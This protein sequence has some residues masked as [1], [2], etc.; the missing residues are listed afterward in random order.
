MKGSVLA[1]SVAAVGLV[2]V[3]SACGGGSPA[4]T[5]VRATALPSGYQRIGG[6]GQG[7]YLAVPD[8]WTVVDLASQSVMKSF[9]TLL[10]KPSIKNSATG[11]QVE[12]QLT[13]LKPVQAV[14]AVALH[15]AASSP[16]QYATNISAFCNTSGTSQS[17]RAGLPFL[18]HE[19]SQMRS[20]AYDVRQSEV[21]IGTVPGL[22]IT[23][24]QH[25]AGAGT[26]YSAQLDALP[27]PGR[28]CLITLDASGGL[29]VGVLSKVIRTVQYL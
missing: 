4:Y 19:A 24:S 20:G 9:L 7:V 16:G 26:L 21:R 1:A 8:S 17:G 10:P 6:V 14:Y 11:T 27:R 12:N 2:V 25:Y 23:Y 13:H 15:S 22:Q 28:I 3:L 29:P 5:P 18:H